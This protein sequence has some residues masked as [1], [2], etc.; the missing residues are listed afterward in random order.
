MKAS[1][2]LYSLPERVKPEMLEGQSTRFHFIFT[3]DDKDEVTVV[4][5]EGKLDV[6]EGLTGEPKCVVEA[7]SGDFIKLLKGELNPMMAVLTGKV[8]VSN[9][10]EMMKFARLFGLM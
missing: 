6:E 4:V 9:Q 8:K 2:F 10:S 3:G 1:E 7:S 5:D